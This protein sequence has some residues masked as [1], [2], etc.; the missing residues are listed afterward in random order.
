MKKVDKYQYEQYNH[1][2]KEYNVAPQE[3]QNLYPQ[4]SIGNDSVISLPGPDWMST[5]EMESPVFELDVDHDMNL[6]MYV[7]LHD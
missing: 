6:L 4:F 5:G 3:L 1:S 2:V 7:E